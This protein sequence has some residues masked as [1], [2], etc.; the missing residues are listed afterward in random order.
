[1]TERTF[2]VRMDS[3]WIQILLSLAVHQH[4][5]WN[6]CVLQPEAGLFL[7]QSAEVTA[8]HF[9]KPSIFSTDSVVVER[10]SFCT[11]CFPSCLSIIVPSMP[12]VRDKRCCYTSF[13]LLLLSERFC[14]CFQRHLIII[15]S[16]SFVL[17]CLQP[18]PVLI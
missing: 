4:Q 10:P 5:R 12:S 3:S 17:K 18:Y 6:Q 2:R 1:M 9:R 15:L 16:C 8:L 14:R 7:F 11:S 13:S